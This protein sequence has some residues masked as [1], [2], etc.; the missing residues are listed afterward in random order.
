MRAIEEVLA[1]ES[2]AALSNDLA[3]EAIGQLIDYAGDHADLALTEKS[4]SWCEQ[5]EA[6]TLSNQQQ[7]ILRYFLANAWANKQRAKHSDRAAVWAWDQEEA[8]QQILLLRRALNS[9]AFGQLALGWRCQILTNLA[10]QLDT[11]GRF[12]EARPLWT[13]ALAHEPAF[14]MARGNRGYSLVHYARA[15]Y[16]PGHVAIFALT[17]HDELEQALRDLQ[18]HGEFGDTTLRSHFADTAEWIARH[19]DLDRIRDNHH[20]GDFDLGEDSERLYRIWCLRETLFLNPLNDLGPAAIASHDVLNLP[21][22]VTKVD[23]PPVLVGLFN[24]LKQEYASARW[25]YFEGTRDG[26]AHFSDR[27]VLLLNTLD[28]P[29]YGLAVEKVKVAFR[30]TYSLLDKV[31]YFLNHY[32]R[33]GIPDRKITFR[34]IWR[35]KKGGPVRQPLDASE[36]WPFRG[37]YWLSKDLFEEGFRDSTD[38]DARDLD[39]LRNHLEHKYVK[40]HAMMVGAGHSDGV[41]RGLFF[42]SLAYSLSLDEL[43][44]RALRMLK[45]VRAALIYLA[46]GMHQEERRRRAQAGPGP[47]MAS[48]A[49]DTWDD[50]WKRRH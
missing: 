18:E 36:N 3:L 43:E 28:Y 44:R 39:D 30:V 14:W 21:D 48:M 15:L 23:E 1:L 9:P 46:L 19:T 10:N 40:V 38:P 50:E 16:D 31:A 20:P 32:L 27:G 37:L 25:L 45:L 4:F 12:I 42:D 35:D 49:L 7:A 29:M 33:L 41:G 34:S 24:Q 8:Q 17:A 47:L 5:L 11:V 13:E 6:R 22:F 2:L 26:P